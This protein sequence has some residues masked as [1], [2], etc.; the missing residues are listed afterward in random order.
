VLSAAPPDAGERL[1]AA[2]D[3]APLAREEATT[4]RFVWDGDVLCAELREG[5]GVTVH[6]HEPGSFVPLMQSEGPRVFAVVTDHLG[7]PKELVDAEGQIAW[8][9]AHSAWG[10]VV[11]VAASGELASPFR[12]LGQCHDDETGLC[13]V[14]FRYF[15]ADAGRWCSPDP[16]GF[17]VARISAG[18]AQA[19]RGRLTHLGS[20][21]RM[22]HAPLG[23]FTHCASAAHPR[24][25]RSPR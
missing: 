10:K 7:M 15:D 11:Q 8:A 21:V 12:L 17:E 19:R 9:A 1:E 14:R 4:T 18:S 25:W 20:H 3:G 24:R 2:L 22:T 16:L 23:S 6:V 5:A 13:Y